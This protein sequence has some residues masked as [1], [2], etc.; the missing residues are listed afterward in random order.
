M[1]EWWGEWERGTDSV[2]TKGL[3][4]GLVPYFIP[5]ALPITLFHFLK[6]VALPTQK[7][8]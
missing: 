5:R 2:T 4:T 6:T 8:M 3:G 7:R 1:N